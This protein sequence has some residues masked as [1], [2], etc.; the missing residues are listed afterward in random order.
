MG[1]FSVLRGP[2]DVALDV[3]RCHINIWSLP[4]FLTH[5]PMIIDIGVLFRPSEDTRTLSVA[6]PGRT[7]PR[8]EDLRTAVEQNGELLFART[9]AGV[10]DGVLYLTDLDPVGVD[11]TPTRSPVQLLAIDRRQSEIDEKHGRYVTVWRLRLAGLARAGERAYV[12]VRLPYHHP[13]RMWLWRRVLGRRNSA[14]VDFRVADR[15]EAAAVRDEAELQEEMREIE[16]QRLDVFVMAPDRYRLTEAYPPLN[17]TR[18]LEG[19]A[20][21]GYIPGLRGARGETKMVVYRWRRNRVGARQPF[22]G[23]LHLNREPGFTAP[24][25][26]LAGALVASAVVLAVLE[27]LEMRDAIT[28]AV[29]DSLS[30]LGALVLTLIG[31]LTLGVL[32]LLW[33]MAAGAGNTTARLKR[34]LKRVER[35]MLRAIEAARGR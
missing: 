28:T 20:W 7:E 30:D 23:F 5:R 6:I 18:L 17:Y 15:R 19:S 8:I 4:G 2:N 1:F 33:R 31:T 16:H 32:V 22:R 3:E 34:R 27:P 24:S 35:A 26:L 21:A 12:R 25:D 11:E 29:S 13:G 10:E 9:F 14:M